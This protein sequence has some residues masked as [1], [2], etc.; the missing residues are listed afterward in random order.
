MYYAPPGLCLNDFAVLAAEDGWN[1]L[2]LQAPPVDPFDASVLETSYGHAR[3]TDLIGWE[4]LGPAF[5]IARP[6]A[7]DDSAV[8][9]MS[10]V[11]VGDGLA[12]F[13]TGVTNTPRHRQSVGLAV[14]DR[15]DGTGWRRIG[16]EPVTQPD[17][18]WYRVDA[19]AAW[20][21]PFV[22]HDPEGFGCWVM[23]VCA[24]TAGGPLD[25][26]GCVG[27]A[28]SEDLEHWTVQ[29]PL[30]VPGD[31]DEF[32]CPVL[33]PAPDGGWYLLGSIGRT[34]T[35]HAWYAR[36]LTD[37]WHPLGPVAP[38]GP[39]AP[40]LTDAF[41]ER[42]LLH[43]AQRRVGLTDDG[44]LARGVLAPPK[45]WHAA[46]AAAP[47]LRWWQRME[48]HVQSPSDRAGQDGVATL[49]V[50][51]PE[52]V[53]VLIGSEHARPL[54]LT[55]TDTVASIGFTGSAP[56]SRARLSAPVHSS[57]RILHVGEFIEVY[58]DERLS[59]ATLAYAAQGAPITA[60][61][62]SR[63]VTPEFRPLKP[64]PA[65]HDDRSRIT[66]RPGRASRRV[67]LLRSMPM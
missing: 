64:T 37:T 40:R 56:L 28:T 38:A 1:L 23:L 3:S 52:T 10:H 6:G 54:E 17:P 44:Q 58:I 60:R 62:D 59:L 50:E 2:H 65:L 63:P 48:Q 45:V 9:T 39:Y 36:R 33:E 42:V 11:P 47:S 46:G 15:R 4:P 24:R 67:R 34:H 5:G 13:Y 57:L 41:G 14:S 29:P 35:V 61:V 26:G 51:Q 66:A 49:R 16:T 53:N 27:L 32:E 55:V 12:M 25:L 8:W 21:D 7:F 31:V 19:D 30:L 18:R 20:R 43:T 22:V